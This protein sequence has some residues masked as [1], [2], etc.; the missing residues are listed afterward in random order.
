MAKAFERIL[1][2]LNAAGCT[3]KTTGTEKAQS[4]C[5]AHDDRAPSLTVTGIEGQTLVYCHA[6]C[7]TDAVL[8]ALKLTMRD[9]FDETRGAVY[10]YDSGRTVH[11]S[12]TKQFRQANTDKPVELYRLE[13]VRQA[14]AAG[15]PVFVVE[16]EKDVHAL[17]S[18]GVTATCSPMGAGKWSK[19]DPSPLFGGNVLVIVDQDEPGRLHAEQIRESLAA[20]ADVGLFAP[21]VGK[22]AADHIAAGAG[23]GEFVPVGRAGSAGSAGCAGSLE[24]GT[25]TGRVLD[26]VR[27]W[28]DRFIC[29]IDD[30]DLDL[31]TLW[32]AHTHLCLE[33]YTTPRLVL[34]SPVPGSGK[35]TVLE[36]LERLCLHPVQMASLSSPALLT[37]MLDA[38]MRTILIDEADRSLSPDKDGVGDLLAVLNSG[39]KRG[40]TR[41]VLVPVK[42]GGWDAV[43]MSTFAPVAM[44]GNNPNLPDDT[45]S[46]SIRVLLMPDVDGRIEDSDWEINE[47]DARELGRRLALWAEG[48]RDAVRAT[49]PDLPAVVRG[50]SR[51]RWAPLKRVADAAGGRWPAVVDRLAVL[52][53]RR[54]EAEKE[55]GI[56][57]EKPAIVL[58]D[59]LNKS[60]ETDEQFVPTEKIIE[61][62]VRTHP[63][64]WGDQSSFGKR[65][66]A[67]RLGR[68]LVGAYNVHSDRPD[69]QGPRG[70][71]RSS[72]E[73]AFRRF[74]LGVP[75]E[76][77]HPAE[78]AEP[79]LKVVKHHRCPG[80]GVTTT[81]DLD[82]AALCQD[83]RD[84]ET[85]Y[86]EKSA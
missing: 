22:D 58:L 39:Y 49:R 9:L 41:P 69:A 17:E 71:L 61:R 57:Q 1:V 50:R 83:C 42:G 74:G 80:C 60:F 84:A 34:D 59:H 47:D 15:K 51:E 67:Q 12:P 45:K 72:L 11:R 38:G 76:P 75:R 13:K 70:Y 30:A 48:I 44:A 62:L 82:D 86:L 23:I 18:I 53:V 65:L 77:A 27:R 16:G 31:L 55:E 26:D 6:G 56:V 19:V 54:I 7:S 25:E 4:T 35:T 46:R 5:P 73:P 81:S 14:V 78:P 36:H 10:Q 40:G 21:K 66:T 85:A 63:E 64:V 32:A 24:R 28:L 68:M 3:V 43:E 52:D 20:N 79:A 2:A 33:T 8:S 37:R 29:T